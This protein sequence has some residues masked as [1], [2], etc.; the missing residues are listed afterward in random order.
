MSGTPAMLVSMRTSPPIET[1]Q[2]RPEAKRCLAAQAR[3]YSDVKRARAIRL[4]MMLVLG[5]VAASFA[6][7]H[8]HSPITP[9]V[10]I[11]AFFGNLVLMNRERRRGHLAAAIQE[12]FDCTVFQLSWN[13][14]AVRCRP[15]RQQIAFAAERY[16]G[17]RTSDWYPATGAL[18]RPLDILICQQSNVGWGAPVHRAWAWALILCCAGL[19]AVVGA[20]W[21]VAHLD[22][23]EGLSDLV[24]PFLATWS[25][26]IQSALSN[27]E[28][29]QGKEECQQQLLAEWGALLTGATA[30]DQRCRRFQDK[31]VHIRM[32]NAQVPDWFDERLRARN[33]RAM[34]TTAADMISQARQAGFA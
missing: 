19:A 3:L 27:R 18:E 29:A 15:A 9:A 6:L 10:G 2:N 4:G 1:A 20:A 34:R 28:S 11:G 12:E 21:W 32:Q 23:T 14:I 26:L 17:D 7:A 5:V 13:D 24:A 25:E 31:I 33:E 8:K 30:T 16:T 22:A